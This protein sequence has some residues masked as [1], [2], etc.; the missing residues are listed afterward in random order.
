MLCFATSFCVD[1]AAGID[2]REPIR[3]QVDATDTVHRVFSVTEHIPLDDETSMTLLYPRWEIA[4]NAPTI[5]VADLAALGLRL[6]G[7][8]L[9]WHRDLVDVN[10]FPVSI[11]GN[12]SVLEA[13]LQYLS[14]LHGGVVTRNIVH[15]Q[16]QHLMLYP[17]GMNVNDIPV[18]AQL[19][20]QQAFMRH[21]ALG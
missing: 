16:W 6:N 5:S 15:V 2:S 1:R 21:P 9:E 4:S 3:I 8:P 10:A 12:A 20:S 17:Q 7:R 14:P 19:R 11:P 18:M 13:R